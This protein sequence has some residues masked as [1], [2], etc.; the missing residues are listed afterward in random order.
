MRRSSSSL[1]SA[2]QNR[3]R[4][5]SLYQLRECTHGAVIFL[6]PGAFRLGSDPVICSTASAFAVVTTSRRATR[7]AFVIGAVVSLQC[8]VAHHSAARWADTKLSVSAVRC[9]PSTAARLNPNACH[10]FLPGRVC[11][12]KPTAL[13][14]GILYALASLARFAVVNDC[15]LCVLCNKTRLVA[16]LRNVKLYRTI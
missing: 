1:Y 12:R 9:R 15:H 10:D 8:S 2:P 6:P 7:V 11:A 16:T 14:V 13:F 5:I 4:V 3:Q